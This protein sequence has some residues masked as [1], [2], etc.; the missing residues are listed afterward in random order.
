MSLFKGFFARPE[1]FGL[2]PGAYR[3]DG[4]G[5]LKGHRFHLRVDSAGKGVLLIDASKIVFLNGTALDYLRCCLEGKSE[6]DASQYM[7]IR[8][9]HLSKDTAKRDYGRVRSQLLDYL[10][11]DE[12]VVQIIGTESPTIGADEMPSPYRMDLALTYRCQNDCGHCYNE[13]KDKA[14]LTLEQWKTVIDRLWAVGIPHVVFTGGE[15]TLYPGIEELIAK[16]EEHGQITGMITNGRTLARPGYLSGLVRLGLDHVQITVL[17]HKQTVHDRL[18][19]CNGAWKETV[20]GLK[21]AI[22]EDLY[23][24]TNTTIMRSNCRDVEATMR[25]IIGLGVKNIAFNSIIRSGKGE[26]AEAITFDELKDLLKKLRTIA[27]ENNVKLIW[28]SPTPYCEFNPVNAGLGIKQ[29]TACALNMAI[30]P[31]G[32][33]LPCQSFY[34]PLGNM[35][36]DPWDRIW[37]HE[38]CR[39]I[40]ERGYLDGKCVACDLKQVCGGGCPLSR[41]HGDYVCLDRHSSM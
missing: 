29:C 8:Y 37:N 26:E 30:E 33:V 28:Y 19:G 36:T 14:E 15:P 1:D 6:T 23:V 35:T 40:R 34:E 13:T 25:F 32:T 12:T 10:K 7:R 18:S 21:A 17:S 41:E 27:V 20:E 38:L 2:K 16:S 24:S 9:K 11:G 39:K 4:S 3:Y 31:D 5:D 22:A